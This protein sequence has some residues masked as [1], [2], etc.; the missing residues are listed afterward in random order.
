MADTRHLI[1][2]AKGR[3]RYV[4]IYKPTRRAALV[5]VVKRQA[6]D[7]RLNLTPAD[8]DDIAQEAARQATP[9]VLPRLGDP[10]P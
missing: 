5:Q 4:Y 8:A 1:V 2:V 6:E 9:I 7:P 10:F 3:T